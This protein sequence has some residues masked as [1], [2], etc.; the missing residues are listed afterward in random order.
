MA[1]QTAAVY[2]AGADAIGDTHITRWFCRLPHMSSRP[3]DF[4]DALEEL[5]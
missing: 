2:A 4:A 1:V 3:P 5:R